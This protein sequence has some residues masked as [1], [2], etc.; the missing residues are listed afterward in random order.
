M[1]RRDFTAG[2]ADWQVV[3][4]GCGHRPDHLDG[5]TLF[6]VTNVRFCA[7]F[8]AE[9]FLHCIRLIPPDIMAVHRE[10]AIAAEDRPVSRAAAVRP[11]GQ[12]SLERN[13]SLV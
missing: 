13:A 5:D 2:K 4:E 7:G 6:D 12:F 8:V 9:V 10:M 3:Q 1:R 11:V